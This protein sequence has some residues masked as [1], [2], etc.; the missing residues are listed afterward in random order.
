MGPLHSCWEAIGSAREVF[1]QLGPEIKDYLEHHYDGPSQPVTFSIYMIGRTQET[2]EPMVMFCCKDA[3]SRRYM[4]KAVAESGL[5][6]KYPGVKVGDCEKAPDFGKLVE[7]LA[8]G[9]GPSVVS[10]GNSL[11]PVGLGLILQPNS[12]IYTSL[13]T[14]QEDIRL[15]R[16]EPGMGSSMLIASLITVPLKTPPSFAAISYT[17]GSTITNYRS[18]I[19]L[20][21]YLCRVG[22]DTE[23]TLRH[24][25]LTSSVSTTIWFEP[26]CVNQA[27][28]DELNRHA[29]LRK[30]IYKLATHV[31]DPGFGAFA[32]QPTQ[33]D[34]SK[35]LVITR[36]D[37]NRF[38][39]RKATL[40]LLLRSGERYFGLTVAHA[41]LSKPDFSSSKTAIADDGS[42]F[43]FNID[44]EGDIELDDDTKRMVESTSR[45][46]LTPEPTESSSSDT[47]SNNAEA[48]SDLM[49]RLHGFVSPVKSDIDDQGK[50]K[51]KGVAVTDPTSAAVNELFTGVENVGKINL[52]P[53]FWTR[54]R[55]HLDYAFVEIQQPY[56][57]TFNELN[58]STETKMTTLF[59]QRVAQA[60]PPRTAVFAVTGSAGII[61]GQLSGVPTFM[62]SL[63]FENIQE[64]WTVSLDGKLADGDSGSLVVN[65]DNGDVLGHIIAGNPGYGTAWKSVV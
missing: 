21:G 41:L 15:L 58:I 31:T 40:G 54:P 6:E 25:R 42:S 51:G 14:S 43:E 53:W 45:A 4:R 11:K 62:K 29:V 26:L 60:I 36:Y 17:P 61:G 35:R 33:D 47:T 59:P 22:L 3:K 10:P 63:D 1:L 7:L 46:S 19:R 20:N 23:A 9:S 49:T 32:Y 56:L 57:E 50:K 38:I 37:S 2:A 24:C 64:V 48:P 52:T 34:T 18:N 39:I 55:T 13:D 65:A 12:R 27:D 8:T 28:E 30:S 44:D 16:L 5:L